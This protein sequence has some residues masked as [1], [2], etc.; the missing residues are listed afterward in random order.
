VGLTTKLRRAPGRIAAG[1][2]ILNSGIGKL[3]GNEATAAAIHGMASNAFPVF[4]KVEPKVFLKALAVGEVAL[5]GA[6]LLPIAP[7]G[8]VGLGLIGFSGSL[9]GMWWRTPGMH[10]PG[11]VRPTQ[12][13]IPVAKDVW[14]L[15]IGAG[16]VIDAVLAESKTT[17]TEED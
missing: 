1:A 14:M 2:F 11:S 7:A 16:L 17:R 12:Q 5:G 4:A 3:G 15:A 13:G 9:L 6:L 10:E 8:L